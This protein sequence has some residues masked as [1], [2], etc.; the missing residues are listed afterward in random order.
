MLKM[1]V[2]PV[3]GPNQA[4]ERTT[5][6][7]AAGGLGFGAGW[8]PQSRNA[9]TEGGGPLDSFKPVTGEAVVR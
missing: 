4:H 3:R 1:V 6:I 9:L 8:N 7:E 5:G 2:M